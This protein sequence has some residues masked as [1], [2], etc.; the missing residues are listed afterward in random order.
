MLDASHCKFNLDQDVTAREF[1]ALKQ[2]EGTVVDGQLQLK[3][4][5]L[6]GHR[7]LNRYYKQNVPVANQRVAVVANRRQQRE[8]RL[9]RGQS[10]AA[11]TSSSIQR[12]MVLRAERK[13]KNGI[14]TRS[15]RLFKGT[16][17]A[18]ASTYVYKASAADNKQRRS[19]VHHAGS[20]FHMAGTKQFHRGVRVKGVKMRG[21]HGSKLSS[22]MVRQRVKSGNSSS[23]RG[24]RRFDHRR[25]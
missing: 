15:F 12:K 13:A 10:A 9:K 23:N 18:I 2:Q 6:V 7:D 19:I 3:S 1:Y 4:G 21:R 14:L 24:N 20:H 22:A 5:A 17:K 25:G 8:K 11:A 16:S